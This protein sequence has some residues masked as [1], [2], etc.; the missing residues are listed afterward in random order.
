[1]E[2]FHLEI[3]FENVP[4]MRIQKRG[5]IGIEANLAG[6]RSRVLVVGREDSYFYVGRFRV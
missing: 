6:Y 2:A 1:M 3:R 5:I 4:R